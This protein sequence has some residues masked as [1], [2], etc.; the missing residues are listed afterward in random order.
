MILLQNKHQTWRYINSDRK[1][2][3]YVY[4]VDSIQYRKRYRI[5]I[6]YYKGTMLVD[7]GTDISIFRIEETVSNEHNQSN[8]HRTL[9][10]KVQLDVTLQNYSVHDEELFRNIK[11]SSDYKDILYRTQFQ[12]N[13]RYYITKYTFRQS[14]FIGIDSGYFIRRIMDI[15]G[16]QMDALVYIYLGYIVRI[17]LFKLQDDNYNLQ[18]VKQL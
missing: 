7:I 14:G 2:Q 6:E 9:F 4:T 15:T 12:E 17:V 11:T 8:L 5:S 1:T 13:I 3:T 18:D 10:Y 16:T